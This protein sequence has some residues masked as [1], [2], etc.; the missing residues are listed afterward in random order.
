MSGEIKP[1]FSKEAEAQLNK[2]N[3]EISLIYDNVKELD[4]IKLDFS[5]FKG[6][7]KAIEEQGKST[8]K[9][10]ASQKRLETATE[11]LSFAQSQEGKELARLRQLTNEQNKENREAAKDATTAA[12]GYDRLKLELT[13]IIEGEERKTMIENYQLLEA[14]L[15]GSGASAKTAHLI[16]DSL[17]K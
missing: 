8:E 3:S 2:I 17:K 15:G 6:Y 16:V 4:R 14:K 1:I 7:Q 13:K 11:N 9:L 10:T 12:S 5:S